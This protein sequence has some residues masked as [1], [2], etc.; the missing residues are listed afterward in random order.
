MASPG[1]HRGSQER[2]PQCPAWIDERSSNKPGDV[3]CISSQQILDTDGAM[4]RKRMKSLPR[5]QNRGLVSDL[6]GL[7]KQES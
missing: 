5:W 3:A 4:E 7:M 6:R 2:A 1:E